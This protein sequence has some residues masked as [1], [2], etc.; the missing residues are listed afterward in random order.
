MLEREAPVQSEIGR[1]GGVGRAKAHGRR[2]PQGTAT[3]T[4][5]PPVTGTWK[6]RAAARIAL[7][8]SPHPHGRAGQGSG[9]RRAPPPGAVLL[10]FAGVWARRRSV[11]Q[12]RAEVS[13]AGASCRHR[14]EGGGAAA[15]CWCSA[16][17]MLEP[18]PCRGR[19]NR[20]D[21]AFPSMAT[22]TRRPQR[23]LT[24][25]ALRAAV[26]R[27][28]PENLV[29]RHLHI[30]MPKPRRCVWIDSKPVD[31]QRDRL[32]Q[33]DTWPGRRPIEFRGAAPPCAP[34]RKC[35]GRDSPPAS[36]T[37]APALHFLSTY[38][39]H[40]HAGPPPPACTTKSRQ[41]QVGAGRDP[42]PLRYMDLLRHVDRR[43]RESHGKRKPRGVHREGKII[44]KTK[45]RSLKRPLAAAS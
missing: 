11:M 24:L 25:W 28:P 4:R 29:V 38:S 8:P 41:P 7:S 2:P 35:A 37:P 31:R 23:S 3:L 40:L 17:G 45:I 39:V 10:N 43:A 13:E 34:E 16:A 9:A 26:C 36:L 5:R 12:W 20:N 19:W 27:T 18:W 42:P 21:A 1:G 14:R 6:W 44:I 32:Q 33:R 15:S 30:A 22:A